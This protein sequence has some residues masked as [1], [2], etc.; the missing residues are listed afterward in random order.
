VRLSTA[1]GAL[2][3]AA[4][5]RDHYTAEW[6]RLRR[7]EFNG[8]SYGAFLFLTHDIDA[9]DPVPTNWTTGKKLDRA[10]AYPCRLPRLM[11]RMT[12]DSFDQ[13]IIEKKL[14]ARVL[15]EFSRIGKAAGILFVA[16]AWMAPVNAE[17]RTVAEARATLARDLADEPGRKEGLI[18]LLEHRELPQP[19]MWAAPI[20]RDPDRLEPWREMP[21]PDVE[22]SR[23]L[24]FIEGWRS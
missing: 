15:S 21:S 7:L 2:S 13:H 14:F 3:Y 10:I 16:E 20:T 23:F 24:G 1:Q 4:G 8:Q 12:A 11:A 17:G 9:S 19:R 5:Q 22:N 6:Q 18:M